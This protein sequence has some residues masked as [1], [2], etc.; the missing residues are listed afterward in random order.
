MLSQKSYSSLCIPGN[1]FF[2]SD[3]QMHSLKKDL[4]ASRS[5]AYAEGTKQNMKI[6]WESFL[7]FCIYFGFKYL[8]ANTETLSLYAQFLS[9]S[10]KSTQSIKNY[11]SGVKTMHHLLGYPVDHINSF[12]INLSIKGIARLKPHCVKQSCAITPELLLQMSSVLDLSD[13]S[14][15]VYWC[16][17]LFAFFLFARKSNLVPSSKKDFKEKKFLLGK[18]K[19]VNCFSGPPSSVSNAPHLSFFSDLNKKKWPHS[20]FSNVKIKISAFLCLK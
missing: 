1:L 12:L 7:M 11:L 18:K 8:P 2:I 5:S 14:D 16:L 6:Q 9:R 10:F 17:F 4:K 13:P 19:K 20:F 15:I 3:A